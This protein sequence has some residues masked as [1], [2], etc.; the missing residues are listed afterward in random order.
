MN[1][2][3]KIICRTLGAAGMGVAL[4]DAIHE[5][6]HTSKECAE[7]ESAKYLEKAYFNSRG[8]DRKSHIDAEIQ[9]KVFEYRMN[10]PLP[11]VLGAVKGWGEGLFESLGEN[12]F[13]VG[14]S[15]LA[16]TAKNFFAKV[17]AVGIAL[18]ACYSILRNG[19]GVGKH[20]PMDE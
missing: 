1:F 6:E 3:T 14:A 13:L 18:T 19:F 17:G 16:L 20:N 10:N 15:A 7:N 5:A 2:P 9:S 12:L 11:S 8:L 4:Y